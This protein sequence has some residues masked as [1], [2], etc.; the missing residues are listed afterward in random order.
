MFR[1]LRAS[2]GRRGSRL[3]RHRSPTVK[4]VGSLLVSTSARDPNLIVPLASCFEKDH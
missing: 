4:R 3:L 1:S 2:R